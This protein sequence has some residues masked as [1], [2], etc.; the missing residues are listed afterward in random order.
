MSSAFIP[1]LPFT[2]SSIFTKLPVSFKSTQYIRK[3]EHETF[4]P[5]PA[6]SISTTV[7]SL[8]I[9]QPADFEIRRLVGQQSFATII[10]WEYYTPAPFAPT[11]TTEPSAPAIRL[12]EARITSTFP[13]LYNSRVM[14]KEFLSPAIQLGVT[15]AEAYKSIY[16]A[17]TNPNANEIPV[18]TLLGTFLTDASFDSPGF[19]A[20]WRKR[21]PKSPEPPLPEAPFLVFRWEG[22]QTAMTLAAPPPVENPSSQWFD[23][24]FPRNL[25]ERQTVYLRVFVT[26]AIDALIYLHS[27]AGLVHRSIGLASLMVNTTEWRYASNLQV[28]IRD[29]GFA[30]PPSALVEGEELNRARRAEAFTPT[31]ISAFYFAED[32]YAM[33]YALV[34]LIFSV[35]AGRPI[36]QDTFKKLF[37]DTFDFGFDE[38]RQYCAEDPDWTNAV[39][40][41]DN[42]DQQGWQL[43][44]SMLKARQQFKTVSLQALRDS[45]FLTS[46]R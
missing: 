11:R 5:C 29:F 15:E 6:T 20:S 24:W 27:K 39:E 45:P 2:S 14:L 44:L 28:K 18:A 21:F 3:S 26:K 7:A 43:I 12:Y 25:V 30:K 10:D 1:C 35:F 4:Q 42:C 36:T 31:E 8:Q 19:V 33:G 9:F 37:E 46:A 13:A 38:I 16:S 17:E 32:I 23:N 41:L 40:F 34:E 22:L